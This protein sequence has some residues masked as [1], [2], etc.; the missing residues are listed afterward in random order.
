MAGP[1]DAVCGQKGDPDSAMALNT[2]MTQN[3][4]KLRKRVP[5]IYRMNNGARR[6]EEDKLTLP[7]LI[8]RVSPLQLV[9]RKSFTA[10]IVEIVDALRFVQGLKLRRSRAL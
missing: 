2:I 3:A 10:A 6:G 5:I 8:Q 1:L 4:S 7:A 9:R